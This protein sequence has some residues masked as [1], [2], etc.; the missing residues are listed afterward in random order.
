M[1]KTGPPSAFGRNPL[2]RMSITS[3]HTS[4][5]D[6]RFASN[7]IRNDDSQVLLE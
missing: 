2:G 4:F 5:L 3:L 7:P 6:G 1:L